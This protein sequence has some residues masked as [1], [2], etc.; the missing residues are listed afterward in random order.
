MYRR[1]LVGA[2]LVIAVAAALAP[3]RPVV[4]ASVEVAVATRDLPAGT[5][6]A[7]SDLSMTELAADSPMAMGAVGTEVV[8]RNTLGPIRSGEMFTESRLLADRAAASG[9]TRMPVAFAD[10]GQISYLTAGMVVDLVWTP[11]G[12]DA[13]TPSVVARQVEV[14][15]IGNGTDPPDPGET[16]PVLV[17]LTEA[18]AVAVAAAMSRGTLSVLVQ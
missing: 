10:P 1:V 15:R 7:A 5:V 4:A 11:D 12:F 8:G 9:R 2:L 16:E 13:P 3:T 18:E 17:E 14:L 6:V